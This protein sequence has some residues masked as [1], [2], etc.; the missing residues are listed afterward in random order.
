[1]DPNQNHARAFN[2][3]E[4][5]PSLLEPIS[6]GDASSTRLTPEIANDVGQLNITS[7]EGTG[8]DSLDDTD[9]S[10]T[11]DESTYA[12][13]S[14]LPISSLPTGLCYDERMRFHSEVA[15]PTDESVHPEDP[16]RIYYI[17][18]EL[19]EAGLVSDGS[20]KPRLLVQQPL[21]RIDARQATRDECCLVH[22]EEHYDFVKST[23]GETDDRLQNYGKRTY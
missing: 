13:P 22:T 9:V 6:F 23:A 17:F 20:K 14:G 8:E 1:M 11:V 10:S 3:A 15:A 18:K 7:S 4:T 21:L 2:D 12:P 19:C 5:K 16:R